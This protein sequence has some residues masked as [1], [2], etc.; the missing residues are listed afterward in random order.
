VRPPPSLTQGLILVLCLLGLDAA[1]R[2]A[3]EPAARG[4][5]SP[6]RARAWQSKVGWLVG[7]NYVP[8]TAINQIEMWQELDAKTIH[9]E[10]GWAKG[11]GMN[12]MRVFLH[13]QVWRKDPEAFYRRMDQFLG[14]ADQHGI[15]VVFV[16]FDSVWD[17][18]PKL[19]KQPAPRP[20][21]HNSGW[22]Q[23]PGMRALLDPTSHPGMEAYVKGV[24]ARFKN[25]R[26]IHAW[27]VWNEPDN[28]NGGSYDDP[29]EA[30]QK[31][32]VNLLPR[33]FQWARAA[34][35]EQPLTSGVWA[36]DWSAREQLKP[37]EKIQLDESDVISFHSYDPKNVVDEKVKQLSAWK[38]PILI[39]EY[40][41]RPQKSTFQ[42]ILPLL[43]ERNV[44]AYNWGFV[45][46][47]SQTKY[48]WDSWRHPEK[49]QAGVNPW[50]HDVLHPDG[51]PYDAAE[52]ETIRNVSRKKR[53]A[54]R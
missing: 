13:D 28:A 46:G 51:T 39:T 3:P 25:D 50:F 43:A 37:W 5:W 49:Y 17:P 34:R 20:G 16:L 12:S 26:R 36:G 21:V 44:G 1:A 35:P 42:D 41:A 9:Q 19:G 40:M 24:V 22:V 15:G 53:G 52:V 38:R 33:V 31:A 11:L 2:K 6:A 7:A 48:P 10:L 14:L 32:V 30:K 29:V 18:N 4:R 47:K 8:R 23:S 45:D 54:D 27:D